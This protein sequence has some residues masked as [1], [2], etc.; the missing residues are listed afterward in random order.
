ML[1]VASVCTPCCMLLAVAVQ[2]LKPVKLFSQQL[3]T[4]LLFR[5]RRNV[6]QQCRILPTLVSL[7]KGTVERRGR[8]NVCVWQTWQG[9]YLHL[10][11][12][13]WSSLNVNDFW[14]FTKRL[15]K[16]R[17]SLAER[18][19]KQYD[20][21]VTFVNTRFAVFFP[22]PSCCVSSPLLGPR[23]LITHG[24]LGNSRV[25]LLQKHQHTRQ[26]LVI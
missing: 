18:F 10:H 3:L 4:F 6:A 20:R 25:T 5:D 19:F 12:L 9:Y 2:I 22:L 14:S 23:T 11:V 1:H 17:W 16:G 13:S 7:R 21:D 26:I 15:C 8:Q 24:V